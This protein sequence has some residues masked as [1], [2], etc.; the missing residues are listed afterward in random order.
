MDRQTKE[1]DV[2]VIGGGITG[3]CAALAAAESGVRTALVEYQG[4]LGGNACQGMAWYGFH[5]DKGVQVVSGIPLRII[6][7]LRSIDGASEFCPDPVAGS[8]VQ[9]NPTLLKMTCMK[10]CV[11]AGITLFLHCMMT[12]VKKCDE[13]EQVIEVRNKLQTILLKS[14]VLVDCT[15]SGDAAVAVG[16]EWHRGRES[17]GKMQAA[18]SILW[19]DGIN[20]EE[21]LDYFD[22]HLDQIRPIPLPE[23]S[24]KIMAERMHNVP[25]FGMGAFPELI[26][27]AKQEGLKDY[28]RDRL[29]GQCFPRT[30]EMLLVCSRVEDADPMNEYD[31]SQAEIIGQ[32]QA[33]ATLKL[34]RGYLPGC[35]N[36]RICGSGHTIGIRE[37][38]HIAGEYYL[39]EKDLLIG[40]DFYDCI[41]LGAYHLDVHSPDHQGIETGHPPIYQIPYRSLIPKHINGLLV[42]GRAYS[43]NQ[44]AQASTR[45]NPITGAIGQAAGIAAALACQE[46]CNLRNIDVRT[47]Q[48]RL[49]E[50]GAILN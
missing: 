14:R 27:K 16:A 40:K 5:S 15:D 6:E 49:R 39:T 34:M 37:T 18:S 45:V 22:H 8:M 24:L 41:A 33:E 25:V 32:L 36:A 42:A 3:V 19:V 31:Y 10:M 2:I 28:P 43:A 7:R 35:Q 50:G 21:I 11:E 38:I 20:V 9:V 1:Y 13:K 23:E 17:D 26:A 48:D 44:I 46:N 47:L 12:D 29:V 30:G 4:F